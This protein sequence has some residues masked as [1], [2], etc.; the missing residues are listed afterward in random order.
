MDAATN[1]VEDASNHGVPVNCPDNDTGND[2]PHN[3]SD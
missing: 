1:E 2:D 3:G